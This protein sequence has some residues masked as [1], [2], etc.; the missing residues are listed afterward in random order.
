MTVFETERL[1]LRRFTTDD[2]PFILRLLNE[3]SFIENIADRGVRTLEQAAEY[4]TNGPMA[5]YQANGFGLYLV[6]VKETGEAAGMC[7]LLRRDTLPHPDVGYAFLPEFWSRGYA[8]EAAKA[9][10][11][12]GRRELGMGTILAIVSP[13]NAP[14]IALLRK[15]GFVFTQNVQTRPDAPETAVYELAASAES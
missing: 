7:G 2:A 9:T 14:S 5:S 10:L 4:I 15:L 13:G 1:V 8:F 11:D 3:P 12:Y 6:A